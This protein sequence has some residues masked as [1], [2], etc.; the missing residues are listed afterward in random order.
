MLGKLCESSATIK[1]LNYLY[2]LHGL[3]NFA[4]DSYRDCKTIISL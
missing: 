4:P 3:K 2:N 1:S